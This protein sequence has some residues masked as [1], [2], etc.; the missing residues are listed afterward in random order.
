[1]PFH[2]PALVVF[3][4][5]CR[6]IGAQSIRIGVFVFLVHGENLG[7][8][9]GLYAP[10]GRTRLHLQIKLELDFAV[11]GQAT[12]EIEDDLAEGSGIGIFGICGGHSA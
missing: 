1:M 4:R 5:I 12:V 2:G 11:F 7:T 3:G 10:R 6:R 9:R 8:E